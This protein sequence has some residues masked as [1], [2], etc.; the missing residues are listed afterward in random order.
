[1]VLMFVWRKKT[2]AASPARCAEP[3][4]WASEQL[5]S[6]KP[7]LGGGY[8]SGQIVLLRTSLR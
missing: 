2:V 4:S 8:R 5:D 7:F 1:M 6:A 3:L